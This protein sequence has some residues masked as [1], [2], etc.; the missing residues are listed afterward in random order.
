MLIKVMFELLLE[1]VRTSNANGDRN[2]IEYNVDDKCIF[3]SHDSNADSDYNSSKESENNYLTLKHPLDLKIPTTTLI[4]QLCSPSFQINSNYILLK[5]YF[6]NDSG[7]EQ[8]IEGQ[9]RPTNPLPHVYLSADRGERSSK[10]F[11]DDMWSASHCLPSRRNDR[12]KSVFVL[13]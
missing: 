13:Y 11:R 2:Y 8:S 1:N 6:Y 4:I 5:I 3:S 9:G 12:Y 7:R 10:L